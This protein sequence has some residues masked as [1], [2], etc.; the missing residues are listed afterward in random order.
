MSHRKFSAPRHGSLAFL[1]RKR[2][3]R[4]RGKV[5]AF[6]QDDKSK[7]CHLT[8][9]IGYKA[10]MT[11]VLRELTRPA[12]KAHKK[13]IVEGVTILECPP[14]VAVGFVGYQQTIRGLKSVGTVWAAN[15]KEEFKRRF[16]KRWQPNKSKAFK[17][18]KSEEEQAVVESR[19]V[20]HA[21]VIRLICHTQ[22]IEKLPH[23]R[24]KKAH[25]MEIQV[26]G[27][28]IEEKIAF[29]KSKLEREI[30]VKEVFDTN[31]MCD[32]IAV[33]KGRGTEGVITRW[34]I[35]RLPRKTHR[36]LRKVACIGAW[37][38]ARV[39][40]TVARVGQNGYHHRTEINKK[41]YLCGKGEVNCAEGEY[42]ART[43]IDLTDKHITPMGGFVRYGQVK[44]DFI[45]IKGSCPGLVKRP[46]T[47][48]RSL[49][50]PTN[51]VAKEDVTL[52][53][54]DTSSKFGHGRFQTK[55]ERIDWTGPMKR[56]LQKK[57]DE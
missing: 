33:T 39:S 21:D 18:V 9:F 51:S 31:D 35:T 6:P 49:I 42:N 10:G 40:Y 34:G 38:P 19:M 56:D 3:R 1:P 15:M 50:P 8:A 36:G 4:H 5:K 46:I 11:H 26:N 53:W 28:G 32:T 22:M 37:H 17:N 25:V 52:K 47:L 57:Q 13:D 7:D 16:F 30:P 12:S 44:Q 45:M 14:M 54:I 41:I 24:Q 29:C 23:L 2:S 55:K 48:R 20:E 27:Q 43:E